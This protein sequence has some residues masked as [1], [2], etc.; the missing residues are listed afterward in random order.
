MCLLPIP[1]YSTL[2]W[3]NDPVT[4]PMLREGR[5]R[6]IEVVLHELVHA[7]VYVPDEP[8]W[9]EGLATFFGQEAAG[10]KGTTRGDKLGIRNRAGDNF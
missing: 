2:G 4:A 3:L 8:D 7:T 10:M 9:N 6:L 1:A 5:A